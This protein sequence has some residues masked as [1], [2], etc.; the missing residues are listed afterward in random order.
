MVIKTDTE[1]P[2]N[3]VFIIFC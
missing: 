3:Y 2:P 1:E